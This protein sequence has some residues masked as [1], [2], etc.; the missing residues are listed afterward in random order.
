MGG[1]RHYRLCLSV[2]NAMRTASSKTYTTG[3]NACRFLSR[4][5]LERELWA[6]DSSP[7]SSNMS[8]TNSALISRTILQ[9][10]A[11]F[12]RQDEVTTALPTKVVSAPVLAAISVAVICCSVKTSAFVMAY[13][14]AWSFVRDGRSYR[15][16]LYLRS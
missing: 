9:D 10:Q 4:N 3:R 7:I 15:Q 5:N 12:S 1:G 2:S 8:L 6:Y 11:A 14:Q 13:T 16:L